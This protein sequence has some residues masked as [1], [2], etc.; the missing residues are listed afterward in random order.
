[1]GKMRWFIIPAIL[2][3]SFTLFLL[4][5]T[6]FNGFSPVYANAQ[7]VN[8][9]PVAGDGDIASLE[10]S[11]CTISER[12]PEQVRQWCSLIELYARQNDLQ[13]EL[14][15]AVILQE[16]GGDPI[17]YSASGAVGLMQVMPC[18]GIAAGFVC[19]NGPCFA[20][21][22]SMLEL[23]DPEFNISYGAKMLAGLFHRTGNLQ[24]ALQAYGPMDTSSGYAEKVLAI[25]ES[26]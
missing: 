1:M 21:R 3:V 17:A 12:Y 9:A 4:A 7:S 8:P 18:D 15:A 20:S 22:P 11:G 2:S 16:S 19:V 14:I 26:H 6:I 24:A 25:M 10:A 5:S 23:Y 13:P